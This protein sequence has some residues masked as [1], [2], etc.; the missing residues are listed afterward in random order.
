MDGK[1]EDRARKRAAKDEGNSESGASLSERCV[2][3]EE[4]PPQLRIF[5]CIEERACAVTL[6]TQAHVSVTMH[7][8]RAQRHRHT[9]PI[10]PTPLSLASISLWSVFSATSRSHPCILYRWLFNS[11]DY[12]RLFR[13][14]LF[15]HIFTTVFSL[16]FCFSSSSYPI[17]DSARC[18][19]LCAHKHPDTCERLPHGR[20]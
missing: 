16:I 15:R 20:I 17:A 10:F 5:H 6:A 7:S 8:I 14:R 1:P 12:L 3:K 18:A 2:S 9:F 11:P 4:Q 19:R 13:H